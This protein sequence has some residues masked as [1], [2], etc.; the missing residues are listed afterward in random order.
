M[1]GT[2]LN[3]RSPTRGELEASHSALRASLARCQDLLAECKAKLAAAHERP[4][5]GLP[6]I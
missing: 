2:L 1:N 6:K 4:N 5:R 3:E